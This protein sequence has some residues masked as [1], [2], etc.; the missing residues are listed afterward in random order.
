MQVFFLINF[1]YSDDSILMFSLIC[2]VFGHL[3]LLSWLN[4]VIPIHQIKLISH[5]VLRLLALLT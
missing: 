2:L 4:V 5:R 1:G 3:L